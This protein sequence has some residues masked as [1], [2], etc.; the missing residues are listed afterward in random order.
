MTVTPG[1]PDDEDRLHMALVAFT[2]AIGEA[3]PDICSY[4]LTIGEAYVPF[5]PDPDDDCEEEDVACSQVW[6]RV[7]GGSLNKVTDSFGG[8]GGCGGVF[9]LEIEVGVMRCLEVPDGGEAP[10]AS[11][12]LEAAL[13]M[14]TDM[15]NIQC[16]AMSEEVWD[17]ITA[18][19]WTPRGPLG[20]QY[21]GTWTF[22]VEV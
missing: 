1:E 2:G 13:Q 10:T 20:G 14:M 22:T 5:D 8:Q 3:V 9:G 11:Q 7:A 15:R 19:A 21:G 16:A 18:G 12:M 4:G 17:S 6:V